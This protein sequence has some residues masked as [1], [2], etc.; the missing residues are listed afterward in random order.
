MF[1][2]LLIEIFIS[3]MW[4]R[5]IMPVEPSD[6]QEIVDKLPEVVRDLYNAELMA[7]AVNMMEEKTGEKFDKCNPANVETLLAAVVNLFGVMTYTGTVINWYPSPPEE[8]KGFGA[9]AAM[10]L[11]NQAQDLLARA[12]L[13]ELEGAVDPHTDFDTE[14]DDLVCKLDD[15]RLELI[16]EASERKGWSEPSLTEEMILRVKELCYQGRDQ[17]LG[18]P[19][20]P[21]DRIPLEHDN[22]DP[23]EWYCP[24]GW[25]CGAVKVAK[26]KRQD[27]EWE[28]LLKRAQGHMVKK[29]SNEEL[30]WI[31][32]N[33]GAVVLLGYHEGKP[34]IV[35]P[36]DRQ[37]F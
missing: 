7:K 1:Y 9:E 22:V 27:E 5:T 26:K 33:D 35:H 28:K 4:H 36:G 18:V 32:K 6:M 23:M 25:G 37:G 29:I 21:Y 31:V 11:R 19:L 15:I 2:S 8:P 13:L 16:S 24:K 10:A 14:V 17:L 34:V 30:D 20:C 3:P 12:E